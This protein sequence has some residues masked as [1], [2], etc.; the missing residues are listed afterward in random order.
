MLSVS[1]T[2]SFKCLLAVTKSRQLYCYLTAIAAL[3][4]CDGNDG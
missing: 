2:D 3:V 4:K 1:K